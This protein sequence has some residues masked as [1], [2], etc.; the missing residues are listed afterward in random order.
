MFSLFEGK[1]EI[2]CR[3]LQT[4]PSVILLVNIL[5]LQVPSSCLV[6][7]SFEEGVFLNILSFISALLYLIFI[8][9]VLI[10]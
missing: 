6:V 5:V 7:N 8:L 10:M 9:N 4:S 2:C 1:I 3:S